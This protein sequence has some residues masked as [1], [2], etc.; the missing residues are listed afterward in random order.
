[1]S[2]AVGV[3][4]LLAGLGDPFVVLAALLTQLGDAW[5]LALVVAV[6][7]WY[8][9]V[10]DAIDRR[11]AAL[12]VACLFGG[13]AALVVLKPLVGLPRPP[14][15][16]TP[17]ETA[18]VPSALDPVYAWMATGDGYGVPSGHALGSTVVYGA[19]AWALDWGRRRTRIAAAAAVVTVV[20]L[21]RLVLGVHYLADVIAG[22]AVGLVVVAL[23]VRVLETPGRAFAGATLV[24]LAGVPLVAVVAAHEFVPAHESLHDVVATVG[25]CAGATA[26]WFAVGDRRPIPTRRGALATVLLGA[27]TAL[28][29]LTIASLWTDGGALA[30]ALGAAGGILLVVAPLAGERLAGA[31]G[32]SRPVGH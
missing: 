4:D 2:R 14:G 26:A 12:V 5:F 15:A 28:P 13:L 29:L 17:P 18:L 20:A 11:R 9:P 7:Y 16:G 32:S 6:T 23:V 27:V 10:T 30:A 8:G 31:I 3:G 22:A 21:T 25:V 24:G 19:L 1:M